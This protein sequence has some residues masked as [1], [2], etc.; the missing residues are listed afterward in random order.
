VLGVKEGS[1]VSVTT[2]TVGPDADATVVR[3]EVMTDAGLGTPGEVRNN[4][5]SWA[6]MGSY[7]QY[8]SRHIQGC[9]IHLQ[10]NH[11]NC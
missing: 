4:S 8:Q 6:L 7:I 10:Y 1:I 11:Q 3:V 2:M 9:S 5:K